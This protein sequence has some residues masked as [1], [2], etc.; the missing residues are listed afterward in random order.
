MHIYMYALILFYFSLHTGDAKINVDRKGKTFLEVTYD[1]QEVSRK[2]TGNPENATRPLDHFSSACSNIRSILQHSPQVE[3]NVKIILQDEET[4]RKDII[5]SDLSSELM[6]QAT[7][8][9]L[10]NVSKLRVVAA[11]TDTMKRDV[12]KKF[13]EFVKASQWFFSEQ[14]T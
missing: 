13:K 11:G 5:K 3:T 1:K 8:V 7:K 2:C 4:L 14:D 10:E 6:Q 12:E 9:F